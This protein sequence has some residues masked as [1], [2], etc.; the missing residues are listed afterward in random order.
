MVHILVTLYRHAH[1]DEA[2]LTCNSHESLKKS[3]DYSYFEM[4][5]KIHFHGKQSPQV[6]SE[7]IKWKDGFVRVVF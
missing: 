7:L 4:Y 5:F 1:N 3:L 2:L 6:V